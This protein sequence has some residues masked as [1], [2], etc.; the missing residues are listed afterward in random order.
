MYFEDTNILLYPVWPP[1][2]MADLI[3]KI[4]TSGEGCP[5]VY[6]DRSY[7]VTLHSDSH[8]H[9]QPFDVVILDYKMPK[10]NGLEVAKE[11][12]TINTHQRIIFTSAF[13]GDTLSDSIPH[14]NQIIEILNKSFSE[15]MLV[16]T[17]EDKT[18]YSELKNLKIY[19][20]IIKAANLRHDQPRD[21]LQI[22]KKTRG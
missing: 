13:L 3:P 8:E 14:L 22:L 5:K 9:I 17:V 11:F 2:D 20:D 16:D 19:I 4:T 15:Q 18:L 7:D 1:P 21:V 12:L 10:M 6:N